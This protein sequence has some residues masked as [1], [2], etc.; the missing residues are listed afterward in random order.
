VNNLGK[1]IRIIRQAKGMKL[2]SLAK[3]AGVSVPFLSLVEGGDRQP[4]L[5]VLRKLAEG[6][7][8]P[9][10]A[11]ILMSVGNNSELTS[12]DEV[13]TEITKNVDRLIKLEE[14]LE[15]LLQASEGT[16]EPKVN[17]SS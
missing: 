4:S 7:S 10:E 1:T 6:L 14:K 12:S 2:N 3:S 9:S 11:L 17:H 15:L 5:H 16:D 13:T 8:I